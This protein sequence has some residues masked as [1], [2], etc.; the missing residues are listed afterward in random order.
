[1]NFV[2]NILKRNNSRE[3]TEVLETMYYS[4]NDYIR[5]EFHY[6]LEEFEDFFNTIAPDGYYFGA[7][8]GD[9]SNFGFWRCE[10]DE[11]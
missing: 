9:G 7:H 3:R 5:D 8:M 2:L 4:E 11:F 10:E 6:A 1:M